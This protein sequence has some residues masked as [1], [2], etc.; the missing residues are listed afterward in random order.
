MKGF[1]YATLA[2]KMNISMHHF[3]TEEQSTEEITAQSEKHPAASR[4][5]A[6]N[7]IAR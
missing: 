2:S 1:Y 6:K 5:T 3:A 7:P 4:V